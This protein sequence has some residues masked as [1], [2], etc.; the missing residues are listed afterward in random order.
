MSDEYD[1]IIQINSKGFVKYNPYHPQVKKVGQVFFDAVGKVHI[2][3][4]EF[5]YRNS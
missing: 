3:R 5:D 2:E 1:S 4:W